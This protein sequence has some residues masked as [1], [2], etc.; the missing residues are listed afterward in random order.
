MR[1]SIVIF[2]I[3]IILSLSG[4]G[5][6]GAEM[7]DS[8]DVT[9]ENPNLPDEETLCNYSDNQQENVVQEDK[10][11][12]VVDLG[13]YEYYYAI[14]NSD[15]K[16]VKEGNAYRW[17]PTITYIDDNTI[18]IYTGA[19]TGVYFCTY[20]DILHDRI[21]EPYESPVAAKY[22][23]VAYIDWRYYT[24]RDTELV[25]VVKDM[26]ENNG[27]Y[28]EFYLDFSLAVSPVLDTDFLDMNTLY[29]TY[30]SGDQY[31]E[32]KCTLNLNDENMP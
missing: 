23:K 20:Y 14:Y 21:S 2:G 9:E 8:S 10:Y 24:D 31:E 16:L 22:N 15:G 28:E 3:L 30:L 19:G 6:K 26:F 18:E 4:C 25:L 11:F 1:K 29:L 32:R 12:K 5:D 13:E 7:R 27:Y 17:S